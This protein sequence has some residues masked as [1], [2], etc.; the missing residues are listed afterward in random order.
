MRAR[1][2]ITL[3]ISIAALALGIGIPVFAIVIRPS[4]DTIR[5][6][7]VVVVP[8][9]NAV[10]IRSVSGKSQY[11]GHTVIVHM[12]VGQKVQIGVETEELDLVHPGQQITAVVRHGSFDAEQIRVSD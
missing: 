10:L 11:S 5:G 3:L 6:T 9:Q 1:T 8:T 12:A 4:T 7:V 2:Q